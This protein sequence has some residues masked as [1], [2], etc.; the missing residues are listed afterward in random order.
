MWE[1]SSLTRGIKPMLPALKARSLNHWTIREVL[2]TPA[3]LSGGFEGSGPSRRAL[4]HF[5]ERKAES[6]TGH[7][8]GWSESQSEGSHVGG[9][10]WSL[11]GPS[12]TLGHC[13]RGGDMQA[14]EGQVSPGVTPGPQLAPSYCRAQGHGGPWSR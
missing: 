1:L 14:G 10:T 3:I 13:L 12:R 5:T 2:P 11:P 7:V 4:P 6:S 8:Q 9:W